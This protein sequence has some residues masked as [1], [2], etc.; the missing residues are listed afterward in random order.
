M[1]VNAEVHDPLGRKIQATFG[2]IDDGKTAVIEMADASGMRLLSSDELNPFT[3]SSYGTGE[4]L[5][6][7]LDK[8]VNEIIIG[9]GGSA[10]VDGGAGLLEA[11]GVR[12]LDQDGGNLR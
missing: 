4:L 11:L 2:L 10:T 9:L 5:K 3:T 12:F 7:A 6:L 1:N 8:N